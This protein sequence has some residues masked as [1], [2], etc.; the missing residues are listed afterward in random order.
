MQR[1]YF[2]VCAESAL[3]RE[4][5]SNLADDFQM[6]D[7]TE[8]GVL[9]E[10]RAFLQMCRDR[11]I[12]LKP[13]KVKVLF[14]SVDFYGWKLDI[15]GISPSERNISPF[16]KMVEPQDMSD[17][18]HVCGLFNCFTKFIVLHKV[19]PST[20]RKR[21]YFY[22]ELIEPMSVATMTKRST[23]SSFKNAWGDAQRAAFHAIRDLMLTGVHL[24]APLPDR[25]LHLATDMSLFGW[26]CYLYQIGDDLERRTI[27]MCNGKWTFS[28]ISMPAV[29]KEGSAWCR[30]FEWALP[31]AKCH[32][33]PFY[34]KT[35]S[36]PVSWIRKGNGRKAMSQFRLAQFD[37]LEW[38]VAYLDGPR[39]VEADAVS[40]P[41]MLG[42]L[43]PSIVGLTQMVEEALSLLPGTK[44]DRL[45]KYKDIWVWADRDTIVV[46]D[47]VRA[48]RGKNGR[49]I[50][51]GLA[52]ICPSFVPPGKTVTPT[53]YDLAV[54]LPPVEY[55]PQVCSDL[56]AAKR[57]F[58][59]MV[60]TEL[61]M[62]CY[63]NMDGTWNEE[64]KFLLEKTSRRIYS[65]AGF[66]FVVGGYDHAP[67][68]TQVFPCRSTTQAEAYA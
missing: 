29:Y 59:C 41:P 20:G 26:G 58:I 56:L 4:N 25:A 63:R 36:L 61:L 34:T 6:F 8:D 32:G 53:R 21:A 38:H 23:G 66:T 17:L 62:E 9:R 1:Y 47:T 15:N 48:W 11:Q 55:G 46:A 2:H 13:S 3:H 39:N 54:A 35:D 49:I 27:A 60:A 28:E 50:K 37:D 40:R 5:Y 19:D 31:M 51:D 57:P 30:S 43:D 68:T 67:S 7:D 42:P 10:F 16:R 12:T 14:T 33:H 45:H 64:R 24:F 22:K 18:R 65:S 52:K 44:A